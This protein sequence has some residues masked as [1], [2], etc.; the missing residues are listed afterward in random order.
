[1]EESKQLKVGQIRYD[2]DAKGYYIVVSID[3]DGYV[4]IQWT[5]YGVVVLSVPIQGCVND[6]YIGTISSLVKALL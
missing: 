4:D 2:E 5:D 3:E 1:M 6:L